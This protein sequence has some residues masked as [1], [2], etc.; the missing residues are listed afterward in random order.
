[1]VVFCRYV[2]PYPL[3]WYGSAPFSTDR[4]LCCATSV[5]DD[6]RTLID[7]SENG[8][9][10]LLETSLAKHNTLEDSTDSTTQ[11]AD[12]ELPAGGVY[13]PAVQPGLGWAKQIIN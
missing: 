3:V 11:T 7:L 1:M 6:G 10:A 9:H 5:A 12:E 13:R 4:G 2:R 8:W